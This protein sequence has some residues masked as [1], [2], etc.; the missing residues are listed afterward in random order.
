MKIFLNNCWENGK[1]N[2]AILLRYYQENL[3]L[4]SRMMVYYLLA[5]NQK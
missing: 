5:V 2:W 3:F 1:W 4:N